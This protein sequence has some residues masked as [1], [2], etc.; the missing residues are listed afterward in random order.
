[1]CRFAHD[2]PRQAIDLHPTVAPT[3]RG[4]DRLAASAASWYASRIL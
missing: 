1:M 2:K 4:S 3:L